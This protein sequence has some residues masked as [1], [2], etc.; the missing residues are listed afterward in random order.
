M[1]EA[2]EAVDPKEIL[3]HVTNSGDP[4]SDPDLYRKF[5]VGLPEMLRTFG[6][7]SC[8]YPIFYRR[9]SSTNEY[10]FSSEQGNDSWK[11]L[12]PMEH[13]YQGDDGGRKE[14]GLVG[15]DGDCV[16][17]ALAT[18][19]PESYQ[20][21]YQGL[22]EI[23]ADR[24]VREFQYDLQCSSGGVPD[25]IYEPWL[26]ERGWQRL[27]RQ[28]VIDLTGGNGVPTVWEFINSKKKDWD[29]SVMILSARHGG[30]R[31]LVAVVDKVIR[32]LGD[33]SEY[34]VEEAWMKAVSRCC[35]PC[36][37]SPYRV[38]VRRYGVPAA[39]SE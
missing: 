20:Q 38:R 9:D 8:E 25:S 3:Y 15:M 33:C 2:L 19:N 35:L 39:G 32:D 5:R 26:K 29:K 13:E 11:R 21:V 16:V 28:S 22:S 12:P 1:S 14:S 34:L 7:Q 37:S 18:A 10:L 6:G 4:V 27:E 17:R 24:A 30:E 31:H 36:T 23:V